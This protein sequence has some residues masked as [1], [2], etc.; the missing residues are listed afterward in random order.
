SSDLLIELLVVIAIIG[1]LAAILLPALARARESARRS[2]CAN[3][4]KQWG[5]VFKMYSHESP[6]G[7]Y[8]QMTGFIGDAVD[9]DNPALP[10]TD[11]GETFL[12]AGPDLRAMYP[13]YLTDPNILLC[14]SDAEAAGHSFTNEN[15]NTVD[16]AYPCDDAG[17]GLQDVDASYMYVGWLFDKVDA[18]DAMID[19]APVAAMIGETITGNGPAQLVFTFVA[20]LLPL[21][22]S[23]QP[24]VDQDANLSSY[25]TGYGNGGPDGNI[26]YRLAEGVERFVIGDVTNAGATASSQSEIWIMSDVLATTLSDF[27][28]VPGG[29]NV[30]Y[31]DGHVQ[32]QKYEQMGDGPVNGPMALFI[33]AILE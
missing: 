28:H 21:A 22:S 31:M 6:G 30:L 27:N 14:P 20:A 3:N 25:G 23:A 16:I 13:E 29:C 2:S 9:C 33:G 7:K 15:T 5:L 17:R 12:A 10:V 8:P 26:V 18:D 1:I 11:T 19:L 24:L 32:F 4:L